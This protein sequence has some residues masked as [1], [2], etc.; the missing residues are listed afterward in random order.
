ML[1]LWDSFFN[2]KGLFAKFYEK[3]KKMIKTDK[4]STN[5]QLESIGIKKQK[6]RLN[7]FINKKEKSTTNL[8]QDLAKVMADEKKMS[9]LAYLQ[10]KSRKQ[11]LKAKKSSQQIQ[12]HKKVK[13]SLINQFNNTQQK[14]LEFEQFQQRIQQKKANLRESEDQFLMQIFNI[15]NQHQDKQ[16]PD[17]THKKRNK[18]VNQNKTQQN[19]GNYQ[20]ANYLKSNRRKTFDQHKQQ[21]QIKKMYVNGQMK[22]NNFIKDGVN[23]DIDQRKSSMDTQDTQLIQAFESVDYIQSFKFGD[24]PQVN[25]YF[26]K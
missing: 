14:A 5:Y 10:K 21:D 20:K 1:M 6:N 3:A 13:D 18:I 23:N 19:M 2:L 7:L 25:D 16:L 26:K 12:Q 15:D 22:N 11:S 17:Q 24:L 8:N 4:K 9:N